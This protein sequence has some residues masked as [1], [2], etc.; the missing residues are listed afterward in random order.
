MFGLNRSWS[1]G[2]VDGANWII[3]F[4]VLVLLVVLVW[5]IIKYRNRNQR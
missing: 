2:N 1:M 4:A 5:A 3:G